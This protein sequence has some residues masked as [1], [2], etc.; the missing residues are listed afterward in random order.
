MQ[1]CVT[2]FPNLLVFVW[3]SIWF[4]KVILKKLKGV[5]CVNDTGNL[6]A[7][8]WC[9]WGSHQSSYTSCCAIVLAMHCPWVGGTRTNHELIVMTSF[10]NTILIRAFMTPHIWRLVV[11]NQDGYPGQ[12]FQLSS[13]NHDKPFQN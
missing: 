7:G 1:S 9:H 5:V 4:L 10:K 12:N 2:H 6:F 8:V 13:L 11:D 3:L